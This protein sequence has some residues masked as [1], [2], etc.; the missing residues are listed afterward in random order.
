MQ[1]DLSN[2]A[3]LINNYNI[4]ILTVY[5]ISSGQAMKHFM[6]IM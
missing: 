1:P 2:K 5:N 4:Y 3:L 6:A